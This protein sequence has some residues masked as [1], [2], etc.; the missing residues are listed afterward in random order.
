LRVLELN[1]YFSPQRGGVDRRI[2][3]LSRA[4]AAR[5]HEV[6]AVVSRGE[7]EPPESAGGGVRTVRLDPALYESG[8]YD[9][10]FLP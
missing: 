3:G 7:G 9:P 8:P 1:P 2:G 6:T 4:L 5:G 10:P